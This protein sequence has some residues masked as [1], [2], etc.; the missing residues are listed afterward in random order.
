MDISNRDQSNLMERL[1]ALPSAEDFSSLAVIRNKLM[2][3]YPEETQ[4]HSYRINFIMN[5]SMKLIGIFINIIRYTEKFRFRYSFQELT[6]LHYF[7][8]LLYS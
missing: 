8:E 2:H 7:I 3:D 1:G 4:K 5:N 6:H